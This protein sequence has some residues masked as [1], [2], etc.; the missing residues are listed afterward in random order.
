M[1]KCRV[2]SILV[3]NTGLILLQETEHSQLDV[4]Y[5]PPDS[6]EIPNNANTESHRARAREF[7]GYE[8]FETLLVRPSRETQ[9]LD[10]Y[11]S[12][13]NDTFHYIPGYP[14]QFG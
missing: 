13:L 7:W 4:L 2:V 10:D 9:Y 3:F 11:S 6:V 12:L 14:A 5:I 8:S 1:A